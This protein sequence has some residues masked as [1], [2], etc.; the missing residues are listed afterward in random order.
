MVLEI[1]HND[2]QIGVITKFMAS[3]LYQSSFIW[4]AYEMT[5]ENIDSSDL[6]Y[7]GNAENEF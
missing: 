4:F 1:C 6:K 5:L 3:I 2:F 7:Y